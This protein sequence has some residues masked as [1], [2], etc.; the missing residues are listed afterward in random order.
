MNNNVAAI[1]PRLTF[2]GFSAFAGAGAADLATAG[3]AAGAAAGAD[4]INPALTYD[5]A[6][7]NSSIERSYAGTG[8]M[9]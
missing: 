2:F 1:P 5:N 3:A 9:L 4:V 8:A 6:M 7:L